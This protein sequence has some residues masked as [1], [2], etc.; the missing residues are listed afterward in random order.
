MAKRTINQKEL[1]ADI[2]SGMD[3]QA[4][5]KKCEISQEKLKAL[6]EKLVENGLVGVGEFYKQEPIAPKPLSMGWE[7]PVCHTL[8][9]NEFEVCPK[10]KVYVPKSWTEQQEKPKEEEAVADSHVQPPKTPQQIPLSNDPESV[11]GPVWIIKLAK[12]VKRIRAGMESLPP[13]DSYESKTGWPHEWPHKGLNVSGKRP[14]RDWR[15]WL[16]LGFVLFMVAYIYSGGKEEKK[17][18]ENPV[19][20]ATSSAPSTPAVSS[21]SSSKMKPNAEIEQKARQEQAEKEQTSRL[22]IKKAEQPP[23][24]NKGR[25]TFKQGVFWW[26]D[27]NVDRAVDRAV[28]TETSVVAPDLST[29]ELWLKALARKDFSTYQELTETNKL[30][31]IPAGTIED[32]EISAVCGYNYMTD[33]TSWKQRVDR[34]P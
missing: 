5:I 22:S 8:R 19:T 10:C 13:V 30:Q 34:I 23:M 33:F 21:T 1:L 20:P 14:I 18:T 31:T 3:D 24:G 2:R 32:R 6:F 12:L 11:D 17:K 4:L 28:V 15:S 7:C 29:L 25:L 27:G 9:L 26:N 16:V